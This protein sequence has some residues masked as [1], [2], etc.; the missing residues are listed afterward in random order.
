MPYSEAGLGFYNKD[1]FPKYDKQQD[2]YNDMMEEVD[3]AIS[4]LDSSGDIVS[5]DVIYKG[6]LSKW[7]RFGNTL[8]LR[9]GM[10]LTKIDPTTSKTWVQKVAANTMQSNADNAFINGDP[11]GGLSTM[12][13]NTLVLEG[14]GGQNH[15]M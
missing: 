3:D 10:R 13:R 7:K 8:I 2:I 1:Y 14:Q 15:I 4:N 12:N 5:G 11:S 9:M 6:D